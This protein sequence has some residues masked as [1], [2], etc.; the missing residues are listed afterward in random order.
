MSHT[1]EE[2][3]VQPSKPRH[4]HPKLASFKKDR[5]KHSRA[6]ISITASSFLIVTMISL[7][8]APVSGAEED[9]LRRDATVRAVEKVLPTIVNIQTEILAERDD[10]YG[11]LLWDFFGPYYRKRPSRSAFSL[12]SGVI[13]DDDGYILTNAH[14]VRRADRIEV[15][16]HDGRKY[17]AQA[18]AGDDQSDVALLRIITDKNEKFPAVNFAKPDDLLLG[19]T[20]IALGNPFGLG[21]SISKGILS[22]KNR[23][24]EIE[25]TPLDVADWLQTDAAINPGNSGGPLIN[26]RGNMIGLNVAVYKD[27]QG[28]GFAIPLKRVATA[29]GEIF[30][31]E[32]LS[33]LWFG[34]RVDAGVQPLEVQSIQ[35][36]APAAMAGLRA[37][38]QILG[39]DDHPVPNVI[40]YFREL[41]KNHGEKPV[42]ISVLRDGNPII[43]TAKLQPEENHY[44]ADLI[45]RRIG[46]TLQ[47]LTPNLRRYFGLRGV[48]GFI[49][50]SVEKNSPASRARIQENFVITAIEGQPLQTVTEAA[51]LVDSVGEGET[52]TIQALL[53]RQVGSFVSR[54]AIEIPIRL[55]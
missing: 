15:V 13:I 34:A 49:V 50:A 27:A 32:F 35:Q 16:L 22:S 29:L 12:G 43:L 44:N 17:E 11:E 48:D 46:I 52:I 18:Y 53:Q 51:K 26:L 6:R 21:S 19:E 37:G 36:G 41:T 30:M 5:R 47:S 20:V 28:I 40:D 2:T 14:V 55:D 39:I 42:Q 33:G 4:C 31:P 8:I 10:F 54:R 38:D 7:N 25:G 23:R 24:P 3:S 1:T 45:R 9:T